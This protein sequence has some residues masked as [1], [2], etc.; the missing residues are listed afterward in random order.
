MKRKHR[1]RIGRN[2]KPFCRRGSALLQTVIVAAILATICCG[3]LGLSQFQHR[4]QYSHYYYAKAYYAAE[5]GLLEA[6]QRIADVPPGTEVSTVFGSYDASHLP[7]Q[8]DEDV[9]S[10]A[11]SIQAD[12]LEEPS[13]YEVC[14]TA[15]VMGKT[16]GLAAR[17]E[18]HP[19]AQ[20]FDN[21]YFLNNF[22]WW[23]CDLVCNG[24]ARSNW[25]FD[26]LYSPTAN[27]HISAN[28]NIQS[29]Y[30]VF[31]PFSGTPPWQGWARQDPVSYVHMGT[32]RVPMPNLKD[33]A[34]YESRA[35]G[36]ISRNSGI[37]INGVHG[38]NEPHPGVYLEGTD[39]DPLVISGPVVVRGDCIVKGKI[40]GQGTLYVGGNLYLPGDVTYSNGPTW[41]LPPSSNT[42]P[43]QR[44]QW[45]DEWADTAVDDGKDLVAFAV[46]GMILGGKVNDTSSSGWYGMCYT[47]SNVGLQHIGREDTLGQDGIRGTDDDGVA[48]RDT[49][50]DGTPDSAAYD[51]DEDGV[52]RTTD[53][54]YNNDLKMT[55]LRRS[56]I[57]NYP[58][59]PS[60]SSPMDYNSVATDTFTTF[61][62]IYYTNHAFA[63]YTRSSATKYFHGALITRDEML[64]YEPTF[65]YDWRIHSRNLHRYFDSDGNRIIDLD[66]PVAYKVKIWSRTETGG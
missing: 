21:A 40:T 38:D 16:R 5:N 10:C 2:P 11:F 49:N 18:Y 57:A 63:A 37:V 54:D 30:N 6:V 55:N 41:Q 59:N 27:G 42:T 56:R 60:N 12:P 14:S 8:P 50:G 53:Y 39:A 19:P 7:S 45:Y 48:Y 43:R 26:F 66:L 23:W 61:D 9:Q 17:V 52:I 47:Y 51:A 3:I 24:D 20:V 34:Y 29:D 33:L 44:Q 25:D 64:H 46:R 13:F 1:I 36:S 62:G 15:T 31:D 4:R 65:F 28:G 22:G 58:T 35:T 32:P